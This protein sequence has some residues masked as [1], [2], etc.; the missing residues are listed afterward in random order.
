M[1][2]PDDMLAW[3]EVGIG[4]VAIIVFYKFASMVVI[5]ATNQMAQLHQDFLVAY[6]ENTKAL[7]EFVSEFKEHIKMKDVAI[8]MLEKRH[9]ELEEK[10][11]YLKRSHE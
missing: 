3:K 5:N 10:Y 2:S 7:I 4:V 9:D 11:E 8:Q 1:V 6:K